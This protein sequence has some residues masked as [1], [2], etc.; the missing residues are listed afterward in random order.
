VGRER[1]LE[2]KK[3]R[4]MEKVFA[5]AVGRLDGI[6]T[7]LSSPSS[8]ELWCPGWSL[9]TVDSEIELELTYRD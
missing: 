9:A 7:G 2:C 1:E 4:K 5:V 6:Q 8:L 3:T